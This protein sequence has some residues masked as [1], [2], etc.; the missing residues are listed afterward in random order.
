MMKFI[1]FIGFITLISCKNQNTSD[2]NEINKV[3]QFDT[4]YFTEDVIMDSG[5]KFKPDTS[6]VDSLIPRN[7]WVKID[8]QGLGAM[9]NIL[10]HSKLFLM[11][12]DSNFHIQKV[13][14][15]L[16]KIFIEKEYSGFEP[17]HGGECLTMDSYIQP[18]K[19]YIF[20]SYWLEKGIV[21]PSKTKVMR[22]YQSI[23]K[24]KE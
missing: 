16:F 11:S 3:N 13:S 20:E 5:L 12:E 24:I 6:T 23:E 18:K 2:Q 10:K 8:V 19:G 15:D 14:D 21:Y 9:K 4:L 17:P 22:H 7:T 1:I